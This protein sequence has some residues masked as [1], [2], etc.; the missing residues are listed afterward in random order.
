MAI[1]DIVSLI[2]TMVRFI[3]NINIISMNLGTIVEINWKTHNLR[4]LPY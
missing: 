2:V 3:D 4:Y 1:I